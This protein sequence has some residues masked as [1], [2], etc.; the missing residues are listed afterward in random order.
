MVP[1][2]SNESEPFSRERIP[3]EILAWARQTSDEEELL[4]QV[5]EIEAT[6]AVEQDQL[7]GWEDVRPKPRD[8]LGHD[9]VRR[10]DGHGRTVVD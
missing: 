8:G 1:D 5:H 2:Q 4:R 3:P 6:G 9:L 10:L 7:A